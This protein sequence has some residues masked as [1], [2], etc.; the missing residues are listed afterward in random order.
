[1]NAKNLH[2]S[3]I[4]LLV[5]N[6]A[7]GMEGKETLVLDGSNHAEI[8]ETFITIMSA[9]FKEAPFQASGSVAFSE[10]TLG[11][12][13]IEGSVKKWQLNTPI[14][15]SI[16]NSMISL[17]AITVSVNGINSYNISSHARDSVDQLKH[18]LNKFID[19]FNVAI[20]GTNNEGYSF[21]VQ[22]DWRACDK[23]TFVALRINS[24]NG[25]VAQLN[26]Y[27]ET[28]SRGRTLEKL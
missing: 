26:V 3:L 27:Y 1:M 19:E 11:Y 28:V 8:V 17:T 9:Q 13:F 2:L 10:R 21:S 20:N 24:K 4:F 15:A 23:T 16:K 14:L 25:L 5:V 18:A 12:K 22:T 6:G 7:Y